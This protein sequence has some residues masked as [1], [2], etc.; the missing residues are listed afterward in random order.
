MK[1]TDMSQPENEF[2]VPKDDML[3][4]IELHFQHAEIY[5]KGEA[6]LIVE[7]KAKD[8]PHVML[9]IGRGDIK[10]QDDGAEIADEFYVVWKGVRTMESSADSLVLTLVDDTVITFEVPPS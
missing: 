5:A 8:E 4:A 6:R 1:K 7:M 10:Y 2:F 3:E 9:D